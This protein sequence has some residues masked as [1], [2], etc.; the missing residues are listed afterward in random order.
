M[1]YQPK[2][3]LASVLARAEAR[4]EFRSRIAFDG[5]DSVERYY[6]GVARC[7]PENIDELVYILGPVLLEAI[8]GQFRRRW[9]TI[10]KACKDGPSFKTPS[11]S[12]YGEEERQAA[13]LLA[14]MYAVEEATTTERLRSI[15]ERTE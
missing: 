4:N 3:D 2:A 6:E 12:M 15:V 11:R 14:R 13:R 1:R 10:G 8:D 7:F 5:V 9:A